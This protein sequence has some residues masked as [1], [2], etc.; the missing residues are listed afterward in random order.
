MRLAI[1]QDRFATWLE[2][3]QFRARFYEQYVPPIVERLQE[4]HGVDH[5]YTDDELRLAVGQRIYSTLR[6]YL[7]DID[8]LLHL[9]LQSSK[10]IGDALRKLLIAELAGQTIIGFERADEV[11]G[12]SPLMWARNEAA[13]NEGPSRAA[14]AS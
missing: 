9:G 10:E 1:E 7:A 11:G 2:T 4:M 12:G 3:L 14:P 13:R 8:A 6:N 5:R